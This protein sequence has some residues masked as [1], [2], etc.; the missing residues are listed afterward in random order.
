VTLL[1]LLFLRADKV[2]HQDEH[3]TRKWSTSYSVV[4]EYQGALTELS[5]KF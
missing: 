2:K 3:T 4:T 1:T 5:A